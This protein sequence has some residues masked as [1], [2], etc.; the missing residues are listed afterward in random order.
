MNQGLEY[1]H[2]P[3][4]EVE[5][6]VHVIILSKGGS[7]QETLWDAMDRWDT[8]THSSEHPLKGD[9]PTWQETHGYHR[10]LLDG[11]DTS[12]TWH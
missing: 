3:C 10:I 9:T 4:S 5:M 6:N 7:I 11:R 8:K 1:E 12:G 2:R